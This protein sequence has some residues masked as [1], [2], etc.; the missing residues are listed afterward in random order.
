[1]RARVDSKPQRSRARLWLA[2]ILAA[3]FLFRLWLW[4]RVPVHQPANDEVEYLHV[5]R[6]LLAGRGWVFY[7]HYE[8]LRAPLYPLFLAGSL[9]LARGSLPAAAL[10]NVVLSTL[11]ILLFY[12][13]GVYAAGSRSRGA[14]GGARA[15]LIA[16][17]IGAASLPLA[18]FASLWMSETLF[19]AFF[20]GALVMLLA[21]N[22]RPAPPRA[23][24]AGFL[25]GLAALTRS[26]PLAA[27]P[28]L[29]IWMLW[30]GSSGVPYRRYVAGA[31]A[32]TLVMLATIAPWT[33]RNWIAY[34]G[35]IPIE[36]GLSYNI[37]AFN[38]PHEALETIQQTLRAIPNPAE[39]SAL[40]TRKGLER[41]REDPSI[42]PRRMQ[43][44]WFYIWNIKP[45]EDR[46]R[47][48]SY[49]EDVPLGMF[50]TALVLDD[51]LYFVILSGAA[52]A[53]ALAPWTRTKTLLA[54]W[55]LYTVVVELL[56]HSEGRYRQFL[57]PAMIPYAAGALTGSWRAPNRRGR[58]AAAGMAL[59]ALIP[60]VYYPYG[61]ATKNVA[62]GWAEAA[63]DRALAR[64]D[65]GQA[66]QEYRRA[67][68][69][70]PNSVDA[71]LKLGRAY[72]QSGQ[73]DRAIDA[74]GAAVNNKVSYVAARVLWGDAL[75][76]AGNLELARKAFAGFY[77]DQREIGDW[78]WKHL[79]SPAPAKVDVGG[80]LDVGFVGGMYAPEVADGRSVRW[81]S[82]DAGLRLAAGKDGTLLELRMAAPRPDGKPVM[83]QVC[84]GSECHAVA[85][86]ARWT[87]YKLL[88]PPVCAQ[89]SACPGSLEVHLRMPTFVPAHAD[90]RSASGEDDRPLGVLIDEAS[91][92]E[93]KR[94]PAVGAR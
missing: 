38:E 77:N 82:G 13:L 91:A 80:G 68:E 18:T 30:R 20:A 79:T 92:E 27:L 58:I 52:A 87:T 37:W 12:R 19:T 59:I 65:Y 26:A 34:G 41:L 64:G 78:G 44:N 53:L 47:Q 89:G 69:L 63:G 88:A 3:G 45:I 81:T 83:V 15:G 36:T 11:T 76:R 85:V 55:V 72:D 28:L 67:S 56:T 60:L 21:W 48:A 4:W 49:Y 75:R 84:V 73:L 10:A 35:F 9:W 62:R 31:A 57:F 14:T 94:T 70:D 24:L 93:L 61:W 51:L 25:L 5:A 71:L 23:A 8:W 33:V 6:D 32:C 40:A 42:L 46:F 54:G 1:L 17:A 90:E 86:E 74:Y 39:R 29:W 66:R 7:D 43:F 50:T 16:A 2:L 22:A